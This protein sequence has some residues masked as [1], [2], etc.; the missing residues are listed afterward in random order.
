MYRRVKKS[1]PALSAE[2]VSWEELRRTLRFHSGHLAE[3]CLSDPR[4]HTLDEVASCVFYIVIKNLVLFV[5]EHCRKT[6]RAAILAVSEGAI[7]K[8]KAN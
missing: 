3:S 2:A 8:T 5:T 7:C 6:G 4:N 1:P